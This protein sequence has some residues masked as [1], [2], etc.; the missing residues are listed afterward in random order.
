MAEHEVDHI[1]IADLIDYNAPDRAPSGEP[2]Y[3]RSFILLDEVVL[4]AAGDEGAIQRLIDGTKDTF[5]LPASLFDILKRYGA[6]D[7]TLARLK[8]Y[9]AKPPWDKYPPLET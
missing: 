9:E 6:T 8:P 4:I 1:P 3:E 7:A 2:E 5:G